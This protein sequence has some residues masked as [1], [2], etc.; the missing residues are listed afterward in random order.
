MAGVVFKSMDDFNKVDRAV[1]Q[2]LRGGMEHPFHRRRD[3]LGGDDLQ[4]LINIEDTLSIGPNATGSQ[5][6]VVNLEDGTYDEDEPV[7]ARG[8]YLCGVAFPGDYFWALPNGDFYW[9]VTGGTTS[10]IGTIGT[11]SGGN[12]TVMHGDIEVSA[13]NLCGDD[14][15]DGTQVVVMLVGCSG[16]YI[17]DTCCF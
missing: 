16:W 17:V 5:A 9:A 1:S 13:S 15:P 10:F 11:S 14:M 6:A 12:Q 7:T 2:V 3:P 4:L 8:D